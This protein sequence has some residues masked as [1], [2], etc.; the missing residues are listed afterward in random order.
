MG[1]K[2]ILV[3]LD[4]S[5]LKEA[6][7]KWGADRASRTAAALAFFTVLSLSPLLLLSLSVAGMVFSDAQ[8]KQQLLSTVE[9]AVGTAGVSAITPMLES[10]T[11]PGKGLLGS[12]VS[13]LLLAFGASGL[14]AQVQLAFNDIWKVPDPEGGG[15][16]DAVLSKLSSL[17]V[18]FL[19][20]TLLLA[21]MSVTIVLS[22]VKEQFN[23]PGF[24]L[25]LIDHGVSLLLLSAVLALVFR[26]IP[27]LEI[28]WGD[29]GSPALLTAFLFVLGKVGL[30]FYLGSGTAGSPYGAAGSLFLLLLWL[31]YIGQI[32]LFGAE[33][34][35]VHA[36]RRG[37]RMQKET[38]K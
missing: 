17:A 26:N 20:A 13:L 33:C 25:P 34:S 5:T 27:Q 24:L 11:Q 1:L 35:Y 15:W 18:A 6:F 21:S 38:E 29:V 30:G 12:I 8:A 3:P 22:F 23:L 16:K 2:R 31:F 10:A 7:Q 9:S 32:V 19:A 28:A 4:V 36:H 37:S 14:F